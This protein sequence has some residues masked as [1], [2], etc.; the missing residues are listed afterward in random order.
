MI[1]LE[2]FLTTASTGLPITFEH[3]KMVTLHFFNTKFGHKV[4][5]LA[6]FRVMELYIEKLGSSSSLMKHMFCWSPDN[7]W[8]HH[9]FFNSTFG[10]KVDY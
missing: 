7:V 6:L 9:P 8:A 4:D 5:Y 10:H 3:K 2:T 1:F